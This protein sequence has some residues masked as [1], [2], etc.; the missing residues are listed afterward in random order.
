MLLRIT[1][2]LS[3][4]FFTSCKKETPTIIPSD[5]SEG[6]ITV[7]SDE[8]EGEAIVVVGSEKSNFMI[9]FNRKTADGTLLDFQVVQRNFPAVMKDNEGNNWNIEGRAIEGPREGEQLV[10]VN[11][12]IGFWFAW[13]TMFPGLNIHSGEEHSGNISA[14][15]PAVG[16]TIPTENVFTVLGQDAI[17]AVDAPQFETYLE[18]D[19]I[20]AGAYFIEDNDLVIVV[21]IGDETKIY[22]HSILNWHEIVND[23][24]DDFSYS[25]SFCPITGTATMWN[26]TQNNITTTF[27][28]S[29]LLYNGNVMPYDRETESIWSQ[30]RQDCVNGQ[31]I[32]D[33]M[34]IYQVL[35]TKWSTAKQLYRE[36][37][38]MTTETGFGKDYTVNPYESYI[39]DNDWLSYPIEYEDDRLPNKERVLGVIIN[40]KAK[41]YQFKNFQ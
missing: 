31:L 22:P 16:W 8:F 23:V 36:P 10:S 33:K 21:T 27:G 4:L 17:P 38:V 34:E 18:R 6:S 41:V 37:L 20:E 9:A 25:L 11:S 13:A 2:F 24:V 15:S 32:E 19:F 29:G 3:I 7:L 30:M 35:E 12:Y 14:N 26:R 5:S 28:V 40:G 39:T 1:I